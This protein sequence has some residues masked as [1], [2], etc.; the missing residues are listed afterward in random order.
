LIASFRHR[1]VRLPTGSGLAVVDK[2]EQIVL[3][4]CI[5]LSVVES[6]A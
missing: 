1:H 3:M 4:I 5:K 2:G 6:G